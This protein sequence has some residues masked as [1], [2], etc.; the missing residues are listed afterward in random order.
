LERTPPAAILL[1]VGLPDGDGWTILD[2]VLARTDSPS[3]PVVVVTAMDEPPARYREKMAGFLTKP[4]NR[5]ELTAL[6]ARILPDDPAESDESV[7]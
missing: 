1:D 3:I 5:E 2:A 4:I 6:L 7:G